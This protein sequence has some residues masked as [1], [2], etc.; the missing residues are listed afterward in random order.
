MNPYGHFD[1]ERREYVITRPDTPLPWINYLGCEE[2]FGIVS[3]T[4]GGYC[5]YR[6]ARLR[7]LTRY[8]YNNVP[9]DSNGRYLYVRDGDVVWNPTWKPTRTPLD[10]YECRHGLGYTRVAG[11]KGGIEVETTYFVPLGQT[12]EVWDVRVRNSGP[13]PKSIQLFGFV[14]W[15][16]WDA[17]DD[18]TNFQRNYSTGQVEVEPGAVFHVTEYRERRD[19]FAYFACSVPTAGFDTSRDAFVGVHEGLAAPAAVLAGR[20]TGSVAHGW[21]PIGAHQVDLTLGPGE[22]KR[23]HFLLGYAENPE[24]EKFVPGEWVRPGQ[25]VAN[26]APFRRVRAELGTAGQVDAALARLQDYWADLLYST[27][28]DR[29]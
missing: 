19:H 26:K 12:C 23:L 5:F 29:G 4:G 11:G 9:L 8:R 6:D 27:P 17:Q 28:T 20:C 2:F 18:A 14:E 10:M 21:Q 7:R 13:A 22:E 25:Q 15:C 16:L 24:A 1:D 3:N